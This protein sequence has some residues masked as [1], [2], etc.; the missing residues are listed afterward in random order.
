MTGVHVISGAGLV[1]WAARNP[2]TSIEFLIAVGGLVLALL[3]GAVVLYFVDNWRKR[4]LAAGQD[5][6]GSLTMFRAMYERGEITEAEYQ[7]ILAKMA[8]RVK[9]EVAATNPSMAVGPPAGAKPAAETKS[10]DGSG[11]AGGDDDTRAGP[12]PPPTG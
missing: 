7:T 3:A 8:P 11:P 6:V 12:P 5:A 2:F 4:Q 1:P 10:E 9:Q